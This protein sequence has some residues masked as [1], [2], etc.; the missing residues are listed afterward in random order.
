M[1]PPSQAPLGADAAGLAGEDIGVH[2]G[3]VVDRR[4]K[5]ILQPAREVKAVLG[6]HIL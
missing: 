2:Q 1:R 3:V 6:G 4:G 5:V